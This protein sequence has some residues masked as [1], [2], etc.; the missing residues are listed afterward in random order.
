MESVDNSFRSKP[1]SVVFVIHQRSEFRMIH[2]KSKVAKIIMKHGE[3]QK[4]MF[5]GI[6]SEKYKTKLI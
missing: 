2:V 3:G 6:I 1:T 4:V 5:V